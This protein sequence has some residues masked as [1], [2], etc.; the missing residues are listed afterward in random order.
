MEK[1]KLISYRINLTESV[2][3][4]L[5]DI[6]EMEGRSLKKTQE[7]ILTD[8]AISKIGE[9]QM[10][11]AV[12]PEEPKKRKP[13]FNVSNFWD[14]LTDRSELRLRQI[15]ISNNDKSKTEGIR[16]HFPT[17]EGYQIS[18]IIEHDKLRK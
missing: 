1:Q 13:K 8:F 11:K 7:K 16:D 9:I 2:V 12:A 5:K 18:A 3:K 10:F 17:L 15:L 14:S 6:A 4:A